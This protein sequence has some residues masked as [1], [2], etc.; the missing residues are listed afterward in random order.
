MFRIVADFG[1][2]EI[3][4]LRRIGGGAE[5]LNQLPYSASARLGERGCVRIS[6]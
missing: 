5:Q 6:H 3:R 4:F 1:G 2:L